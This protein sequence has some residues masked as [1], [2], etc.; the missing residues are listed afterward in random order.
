MNDSSPSEPLAAGWAQL[1]EGHWPAARDLFEQALAL[2][3]SAEGYEGLSWAAWWLD[4][5]KAVF[6]CRERAFRM[7]RKGDDPCGAARMAVWLAADELDFHGAKAVAQGWIR[8]AQRLLEPLPAGVDHGWLAFQEGFLA[9]A[10]GDVATAARSAVKAADLGRRLGVADLEMLGLALE[11]ATLVACARID[12]GMRMLDESTTV[13]LEGRATIPISSAW[14]CCFLVGACTSVRDFDR[15]AQWC[16]R[17]AGFADRYSSR[18]M[19][20]FCRAE[21]GEVHLWRGDWAEAQRVLEMSIQDFAVSRPA[22]SEGPCAV[23]AELRRR[24]GRLEEALELLGGSSSPAALVCEAWIELDR[25]NERRCV[26]LAERALRQVPEFRLTD[27]IPIAEVLACGASA[28]ED[29]AGAEVALGILRLAQQRIGTAPLQPLT[30]RAEGEWALARGEQDHARRLLEDAVDGF[31]RCGA[32]YEAA[33]TRIDLAF[34][35]QALGR[36]EQAAQQA[37]RARDK[38]DSMGAVV[39]ARRARRLLSGERPHDRIAS[40]LTAREREVLVLLARGMTNRALAEHLVISEHTVHR[41]VG[42]ILRKL[43]LPSRT[44]AAA[45]WV[46]E[47]IAGSGPAK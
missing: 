25:G 12:E 36:T 42:N 11:G 4:D 14:A 38:L 47:G 22:W 20:A 43:D 24:Q 28:A 19:L 16:D 30:N 18:W 40:V 46:Q 15:A 27:R 34:C 13:A 44:A 6:A 1:Q 31:V 9:N 7:Y 45:W 32:P 2:A 23:L 8:R 17:I 41:H 37:A 33:R 39:Q 29:A 21:Y 26:E 3:D 5:E 35:L 10:A